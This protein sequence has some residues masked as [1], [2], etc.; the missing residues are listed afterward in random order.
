MSTGAQSNWQAM[1][2][3][4]AYPCIDGLYVPFL[5]P[6]DFDVGRKACF[7]KMG[8]VLAYTDKHNFQAFVRQERC[9]D[10]DNMPPLIGIAHCAIHQ[11]HDTRHMPHVDRMFCQQM[12]DVLNNFTK[13]QNIPDVAHEVAWFM[14]TTLVAASQHLSGVHVEPEAHPV[15][16]EQDT[17]TLQ[18][19]SARIAYEW[20]HR[21]CERVRVSSFQRKP[22]ML[23]QELTG[24]W[25]SQEQHAMQTHGVW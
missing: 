24:L 22:T 4:P 12:N 21:F 23:V 5:T 9:K 10:Q 18:S 11:K 25:P 13:Y 17:R 14:G 15:G 8:L 6:E 20:L 19:E 1:Q 3:P 7:D 16:V 2:G